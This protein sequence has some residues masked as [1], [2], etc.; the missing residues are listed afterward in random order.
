MTALR[1]DAER[2]DNNSNA[3]DTDNT[4]DT[5]TTNSAEDDS[6]PMFPG[7][8][9]WIGVKIPDALVKSFSTRCLKIFMQCGFSIYSC[10]VIL[11]ITL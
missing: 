7:V 2:N 8:A 3:D 4:G 10:K 9:F 11:N 1:K 6:L 5:E